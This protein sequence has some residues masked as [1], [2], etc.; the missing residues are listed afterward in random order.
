M[1]HRIIFAVAIDIELPHNS[2]SLAIDTADTHMNVMGEIGGL[3]GHE[4]SFIRISQD[5]LQFDEN[6]PAGSFDIDKI[7]EGF[8]NL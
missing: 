3:A 4:V 1:K 6:F 7:I 2:V 5:A 8:D